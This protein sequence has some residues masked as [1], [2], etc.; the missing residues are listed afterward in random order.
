MSHT[1]EDQG[2][3]QADP[4]RP[5]GTA[6]PA[7]IDKTDKTASR[8][9]LPHLTP[10][11]ALAVIWAIAFA[12]LL[13]WGL[14]ANASAKP[15]TTACQHAGSVPGVPST[16]PGKPAQ[17]KPRATPVTAVPFSRSRTIQFR[18]VEYDVADPCSKVRR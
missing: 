10:I 8:W 13:A 18:Q 17:L 15:D 9:K 2:N 1:G 5:H 4:S 12:V 3:Q 6:N 14:D 7:D 11:V 16:A